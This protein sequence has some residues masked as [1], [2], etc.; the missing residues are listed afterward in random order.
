MLIE[1]MVLESFTNYTVVCSLDNFSTELPMMPDFGG[2]YSYML[3][4]SGMADGQYTLDVRV[5][6]G[7]GQFGFASVTFT[8]ENTP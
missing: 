2:S 6:D 5:E 8:V 3:D 1:A 7:I 4:T